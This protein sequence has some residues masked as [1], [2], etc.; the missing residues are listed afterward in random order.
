MGYMI[1]SD[2][3]AHIGDLRTLLVAERHR[4]TAQIGTQTETFEAIVEAAQLTS[5]DDEHDP[6]G[7]TL[8]FERSQADALRSAAAARLIEIEVAIERLDSSTYGQCERCSLP[9]AVERLLARPI[10]TLCM[11]C[12]ALLS[13]ARSR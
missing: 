5:T 4:V 10:A 3:S 1:S 9:I 13:P 7:A 2:L 12:A 8:A 11:P 6:E